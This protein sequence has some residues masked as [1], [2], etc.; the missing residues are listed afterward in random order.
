MALII[1]GTDDTDPW[2]NEKANLVSL[3]RFQAQKSSRNAKTFRRIFLICKD[4]SL[5]GWIKLL[6]L[7]KNTAKIITRE[8]IPSTTAPFIFF[9]MARFCN[10]AAY[11]NTVSG[12]NV[13]YSSVQWLPHTPGGGGGSTWVNVCW[14]FAAGLSEPLPPQ[15]PY[16]IIVYFLANYRS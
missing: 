11:R 4:I 1:G 3:I 2:N 15:S 13:R 12:F 14:V 10:L 5:I 9:I 6:L 16:P 8:V 7:L